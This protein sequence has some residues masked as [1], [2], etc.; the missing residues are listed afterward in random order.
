MN[1]AIVV[2]A[3]I[4]CAACSVDSEQASK[5][6]VTYNPVRQSV[7]LPLLETD[8]VRPLQFGGD[9]ISWKSP[10]SEAK[11]ISQHTKKTVYLDG[12][13]I[14]SEDDTYVSG[15][16]ISFKAVDPDAGEGWEELTV[17]Y[18]Y[19][20]QKWLCFWKSDTGLR[21]ISK[22]ESDRI[23]KSWGLCL[24]QNQDT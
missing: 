5:F 14:V 23:L 2:F 3:L 24:D 20:H 19:R 12:A 16:W 8:W 22:S 21:T 11:G 7:G 6:G 4:S 9:Q 10:R 1:S 15:R 17:R 18:D 13:G